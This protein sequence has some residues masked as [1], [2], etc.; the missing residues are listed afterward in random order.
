[1]GGRESSSNSHYS[2]LT[3]FS[4][5]KRTQNFVHYFLVI[6]LFPQVLTVRIYFWNYYTSV[7]L[8]CLLSTEMSPVTLTVGFVGIPVAGLPPWRVSPSKEMQ[9]LSSWGPRCL[10]PNRIQNKASESTPGKRHTQH[11]QKATTSKSALLSLV[12]QELSYTWGLSS[13][14]SKGRTKTAV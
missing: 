9:L 5:I 4:A 11:Q 14:D 12:Y 13:K 7:L 6:F 1:M 8:F 10:E 3:L 2:L